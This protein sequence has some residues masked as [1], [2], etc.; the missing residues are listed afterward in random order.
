[1]PRNLQPPTS[2]GFRRAI[3]I[4]F[5]ATGMIQDRTLETL[6]SQN[7]VISLEFYPSGP[8]GW[9]REGATATLSGEEAERRFQGLQIASMMFPKFGISFSNLRPESGNVYAADV[10]IEGADGEPEAQAR[11][12]AFRERVVPSEKLGTCVWN[13]RAPEAA[14]GFRM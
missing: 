2:P 13:M 1:V 12:D 8:A 9:I 3:C 5:N 10:V 7:F 11:L 4:V 6:M 14:A